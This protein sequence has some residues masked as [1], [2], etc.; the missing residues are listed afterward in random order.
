M[1][2]DFAT[3]MAH[4]KFVTQFSADSF[5]EWIASAPTDSPARFF[6]VVANSTKITFCAESEPF[7]PMVD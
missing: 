2:F 3:Q 5:T 1:N 4:M 7:L 6:E